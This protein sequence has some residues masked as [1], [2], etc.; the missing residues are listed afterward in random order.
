LRS[1]DVLPYQRAMAGIGGPE[2]FEVTL[3]GQSFNP[4]D[5]IFIGFGER[6]DGEQMAVAQF[7]VRWNVPEA[8]VESLLVTYGMERLA[9]LSCSELTPVHARM[10]RFLAALHSEERVIVMHDPFEPLAPQWRERFATLLLQFVSQKQAIV[11]VTQLS[12]RPECWI[13]EDR[14]VRIQ[15]GATQQQTIGFS[16]EDDASS[17]LIKKVRS[18]IAASNKPIPEASSPLSMLT[19]KTPA[20][21]GESW[22]EAPADSLTKRAP[23]LSEF[24]AN[25]RFR[26]EDIFRSHQRALLG[27]LF[28][29]AIVVVCLIVALRKFRQ[30][31]TEQGGVTVV[32]HAVTPEVTPSQGNTYSTTPKIVPAV[33]HH[34]PAPTPTPEPHL[35]DLYPASIRTAVLD[36]FRQPMPREELIKVSQVRRAAAGNDTFEL[37]KMLESASSKE[38]GSN[39]EPVVQ[40]DYTTEPPVAMP[41]SDEDWEARR[42]LMRQRFLESIESLK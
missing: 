25:R 9:G 32:S 29:A 10:L 23:V 27:S 4:S 18:E 16:Q 40:R 19:E 15:V 20:D 30:S 34:T 26:V 12:S 33:V 37:L 42:E 22:P 35:L 24:G 21:P 28:T 6:F 31:R 41:A 11:L 38:P 5:H 7:L 17:E 36:A 13:G 14:I 1:S 39:T 8:M 3:D 2:R